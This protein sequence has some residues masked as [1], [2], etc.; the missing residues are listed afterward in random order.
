MISKMCSNCIQI[1][2]N[3]TKNR[4]DLLHLDQ[5][6]FPLIFG[7]GIEF[8]VQHRPVFSAMRPRL[9][10]ERVRQEVR[11]VFEILVEILVSPAVTGILFQLR[12]TPSL[13]KIVN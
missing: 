6:L 11:G 3:L 2:P 8:P 10:F 9:E 1:V 7:E 13:L 5:S 12:S 4:S